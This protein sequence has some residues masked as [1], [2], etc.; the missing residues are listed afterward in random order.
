MSNQ[1]ENIL[2]DYIQ[3][4][5]I[6]N[7]AEMPDWAR[8][9]PPDAQEAIRESLSKGDTKVEEIQAKLEEA[10]VKTDEAKKVAEKVKDRA[11][12]IFNTV[13]DFGRKTI[14]GK[15]A[16]GNNIGLGGKIA[17]TAAKAGT[18]VSERAET[19]KAALEAAAASGDKA[20]LKDQIAARAGGV[21]SALS[22]I[23]E[24]NASLIGGAAIGGAALVGG[25]TA[26]LI[27]RAHTKK[28]MKQTGASSKAELKQLLIERKLMAK[29]L[30]AKGKP[31]SEIKM[32][33]K[34]KY[35]FSESEQRELE[36]EQ[37][38]VKL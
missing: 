27:K 38:L 25:G 20:G 4:N 6:D 26:A 2:D 5:R 8:H 11:R 30:K 21:G 16:D 29:A 33:L 7:F 31:G 18:R 24:G 28:R 10:G 12:S 32:L 22:K 3:E 1:F 35:G 23:G 34:E 13:K 19:A 36:Q 15:N 37:F 17:D 9:L 14:G